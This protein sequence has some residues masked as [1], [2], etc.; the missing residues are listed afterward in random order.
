MRGR[1]P[2]RSYVVYYGRG[3]LAGIDS[4]DIAI[5]EPEGW[6]TPSLRQLQGQSVLT[7]AYVS[8]LEVPQ[9]RMPRAKLRESDL[10]YLDNKPW[11]RDPFGNFL[12]RPDSKAWRAYLQAE[13]EMLYRVGWDGLFLDTLGDA[14][15]ETL[16]ARAGWLLPAAA[17]LTR[18]IRNTFPSR[19]IIVNNGLWRVVPLIA[20]YIDGVCWEGD[21]TPE[22]LKE[23]WAQVIIEFL[24]SATQQRGW[25]NF[26]LTHIGGNSLAAAQQRLRFAEDADR[27][28]FLSYAAPGNYADAILL[29]D[30]RVVGSIK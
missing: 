9:W 23:P 14:E 1:L 18:L 24:G 10:F 25:V 26:M 19:P 13:V 27:Y 5:L 15:D 11:V 7:L 20:D 17:D 21:L 16:L 30:G 29:R 8:A 3:P 28:G 4:Y 22:V 6:N 2:G 12:A